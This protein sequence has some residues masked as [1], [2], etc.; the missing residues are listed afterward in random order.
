MKD[1]DTVETLSN[2]ILEQEHRI[3]VEAIKLIVEGKL[4]IQGRRVLIKERLERGF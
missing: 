1:D 4:E 3:Y 2:R